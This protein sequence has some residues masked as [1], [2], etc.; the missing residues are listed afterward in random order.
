VCSKDR[1]KHCTATGKNTC[2]SQRFSRR[3]ASNGCGDALQF[4]P[5]L[6]RQIRIADSGHGWNSSKC[7]PS[8]HM[9]PA[10]NA[11]FFGQEEKIKKF[12]RV[13]DN[14]SINHSIKLKINFIP[15]F[16]GILSTKNQP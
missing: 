6:C 4:S 11:Q 3:F 14:Q 8:R 10:K 2:R 16:I 12:P 15:L 7:T 5:F 1:R 9:S 13:T